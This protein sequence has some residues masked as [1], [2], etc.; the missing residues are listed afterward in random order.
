LKL[1][2]VNLAPFYDRMCAKDE[3]RQC[4]STFYEVKISKKAKLRLNFSTFPLVKFRKIWQ[5]G[6]KYFTLV[7][8]RFLG[9]YPYVFVFKI[10]FPLDTMCR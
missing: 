4:F 8:A 10:R 6:I 7:G 3:K 1:R 9:S 5:A 2:G